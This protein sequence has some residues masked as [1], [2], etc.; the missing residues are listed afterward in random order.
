MRERRRAT[1][2]TGIQEMLLEAENAGSFA[3]EGTGWLDEIIGSQHFKAR[4]VG[5][6]LRDLH[7]ELLRR[8]L[9]G[10][11]R[12]DGV[13]T[14][15]SDARGLRIVHDDLDTRFSLRYKARSQ[16]RR[17]KLVVEPAVPDLE[18]CVPRGTDLG[19]LG[20]G[21]LG[22]LW[23][24]GMIGMSIGGALGDALGIGHKVV[25]M[26]GD[27]HDDAYADEVISRREN[28]FACG[29]RY[30]AT[31]TEYGARA[32]ETALTLVD[33]GLALTRRS[34]HERARIAAYLLDAP[35]PNPLRPVSAYERFTA[36]SRFTVLYSFATKSIG[37][38][39][40][41]IFD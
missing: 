18:V 27:M 25:R 38:G 30:L 19:E 5:S 39:I 20:L 40:T 14:V 4:Y 10:F 3:E 31:N 35:E 26:I 41:G 28:T 1:A 17:Y 32:L 36:F 34:L 37:K 29:P 16:G 2:D 33:E 7:H 13:V 12:Q 22:E 6:A 23:L 21:L 8:N 11:T 24:P 9:R 15:R